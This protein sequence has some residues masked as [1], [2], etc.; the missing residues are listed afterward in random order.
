MDKFDTTRIIE[1]FSATNENHEC[2]MEIMN[3]LQLMQSRLISVKNQLYSVTSAYSDSIVDAVEQA[4]KIQ[5]GLNYLKYYFEDSLYQLTNVQDKDFKLILNIYASVEAKKRV[6]KFRSRV[7]LLL[8]AANEKVEAQKL[9][10]SFQN[11]R[12]MEI[13]SKTLSHLDYGLYILSN[14]NLKGVILTHWLQ[15]D[16]QESF[17]PFLQLTL[18][19]LFEANSSDY[20]ELSS[21]LILM[22][23][24]IPLNAS[25]FF[26]TSKIVEIYFSS[27]T[28]ALEN[29]LNYEFSFDNEIKIPYLDKLDKRNLSDLTSYL[30]KNSILSVL[31]KDLF[32]KLIDMS[33]LL[34]GL[35]TFCTQSQIEI[36]L[37]D[38]VEEVYKL[39]HKKLSNLF[40]FN[41]LFS[42][43]TVKYQDLI[44][45]N[46]NLQ[47]IKLDPI[48]AS[49]FLS[50][51]IYFEVMKQEYDLSLKD[52]IKQIFSKQK[53]DDLIHDI[54]DNQTESCF[55]FHNLKTIWAFGH[56]FF[57]FHTYWNIL[58]SPI[59]KEFLLKIICNFVDAPIFLFLFKHP[60]SP[61]G[62]K[63][64][65]LRQYFAFH[66]TKGNL[67]IIPIRDLLM[68]NHLR[69]DNGETKSLQLQSFLLFFAQI[70]SLVIS[71]PT[72]FETIPSEVQELK[73]YCS[74][75]QQVGVL[76]LKTGLRHE[77]S[78]FAVIESFSEKF[79]P[80]LTV[81]SLENIL[82]TFVLSVKK[83]LGTH[84][85][86]LEKSGPIE[87]FNTELYN[88][89]CNFLS[90]YLKKKIGI[91][92]MKQID[93][94]E[95]VRESLSLEQQISIQN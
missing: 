90:L 53:V 56:E 76:L 1:S 36:E 71:F 52:S 67:D 92:A 62:K 19:K 45:I 48:Q 35:S 12:Q 28:S 81:Q 91:E 25:F 43:K 8:V 60:G 17:L 32:Q 94:K 41:E 65:I 54:F 47:R 84:I 7:K 9:I 86:L 66:F 23:Q 4:Q 18:R 58:L 78:S 73:E 93:V 14:D 57:T 72:C 30:K 55:S 40:S 15:K 95:N 51:E 63:F 87:M 68:E 69:P 22:S 16:I 61:F 44:S 5:I 85:R 89:V 29:L 70:E 79:I 11:P 82:N 27:F 75:L 3:S 59:C 46:Y 6:Q 34:R 10:S 26:A 13:F 39:I 31:T 2:D 38:V 33:S 24:H 80:G 42:F 50:M 77:L 88:E 83:H 20:E 64:Q 37:N 74:A 21:F 49:N